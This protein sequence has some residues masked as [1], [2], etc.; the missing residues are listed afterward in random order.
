LVSLLF[1]ELES[2]NDPVAELELQF[3]QKKE[4]DELSLFL[5]TGVQGK[6]SFLSGIHQFTNAMQDLLTKK[7][8]NNIS[9]KGN[10]YDQV[11]IAYAFPRVI[12][13]V[14]V[15]DGHLFNMF[16]TDLNGRIDEEHYVISLRRDGK[17]NQQVEELKKICLS[18]VKISF[19]KDAYRMGK[20]HMQPLKPL[21]EFK[22][23]TEKSEYLRLPLPSEAFAYKELE[24]T[25]SIDVGI[26]R[27]HFLK[28]LHEKFLHT[29]SAL[30]HVHRFYAAWEMKQGRKTPYLIH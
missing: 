16:P 18:T 3:V 7:K 17:V 1:S 4:F 20:N 28:I 5:F 9:L 21:E 22:I 14:T 2:G 26:H 27:L 23:S 24:L 12:S 29:G 15:G 19:C 10:L 30:A 13:I 25:D 11:R 6:H 8:E